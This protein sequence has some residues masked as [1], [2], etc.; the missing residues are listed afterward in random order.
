MKLPLSPKYFLPVI[1]FTIVLGYVGYQLSGLARRPAFNIDYPQDG[2]TIRDELLTIRGR[3][4]GLTKLFLD[5]EKLTPREDG[6]FEVK[7][8]LA[9]GYNI[10]SLTGAD[11]FGRTV[12]KKLQLLYVPHG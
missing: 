2:T 6:Q 5:D 8:L 7:L 9:K 4:A 10:I 1:F 11:R 12:E 3:A